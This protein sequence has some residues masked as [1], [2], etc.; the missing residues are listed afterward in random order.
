MCVEGGEA[1]V[2]QS[3]SRLNLHLYCTQRT[4][5][6]DT[7][8]VWPALPLIVGGGMTSTS[9]MDNIIVALEQSNRVRQVILWELVDLQ[10]EKVLAAMQVP[11]LELTNLRLWSDDE[12][13]PVIPIPDSFLGGSAPRLQYF[14]L[15]GIPFPGLPNLLLVCRSPCPPSS[16]RYSS[17]RIHFTRRDGRCPLHFVQPRIIFPSIP[18]PSISS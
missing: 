18:I 5:T 1:F 11:F 7:L 2:F 6:R 10:L 4:P 12:T 13:P 15:S 9:D 3:S 14:E 8:D 16:L 17:F